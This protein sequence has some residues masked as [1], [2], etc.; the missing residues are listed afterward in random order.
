MR[1][2][3][4]VCDVRRQL[5]DN[6]QRRVAR[7]AGGDGGSGLRLL[8]EL[9]AAALRVWAAYV[10]FESSDALDVLQPRRNVAV[11]IG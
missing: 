10:Q 7:H 2:R 3:P 9:H 11:L 1:D 4:R 6:R 8:A 5:D